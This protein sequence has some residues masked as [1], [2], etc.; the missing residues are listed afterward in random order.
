M[1]A[2]SRALLFWAL[3]FGALLSSDRGA[4]DPMHFVL[5][6]PPSPAAGNCLFVGFSLYS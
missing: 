3:L 1:Q 2:R 4:F 6:L 5:R